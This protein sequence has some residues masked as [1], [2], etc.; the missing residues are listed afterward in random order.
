MSKISDKSQVITS[1]LGSNNVSYEENTGR[2]EKGTIFDKMNEGKN[3][4]ILKQY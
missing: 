4:H 3:L 2:S 1:K